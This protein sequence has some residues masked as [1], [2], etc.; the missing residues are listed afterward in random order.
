MNYSQTLGESKFFGRCESEFFLKKYDGY[1]KR[2]TAHE[3]DTLGNLV[4]LTDGEHGNAITSET[5]YAKYYGARNVLKGI[6]DEKD[7][8][9]IS[10]EHHRRIWK[11]RL[12]ANDVL[13]SCV[14]ANVGFASIVPDNVGEA[15]IVRNVAL[16][17]SLNPTVSNHYL[18]AY[19]LSKYGKELFIRMATGNAQ[20]LVSLDYIKTIPVYIP[21][22]KFQIKIKDAIES[23][24]KN[25]DESQIIYAQAEAMLL[26][27]IGLA[28]FEPSR[29]PVNVK[30]FKESFLATGRLDAEYY[31]IKYEQIIQRIKAQP[32][33]SL[34][35]LVLMTKSIEPGS[36]AY[37]DEGLPF[38]RVSDFNKYGLS[39][40]AVKLSKEYYRENVH[41]LEALKPKKGTILF[42][43]DGSVGVAYLLREN[44]NA[45]TSSAILH[46]NILNKEKVLPE[47]L[48]LVLNSTLVQMQAERD[49][50]GSIILHWRM[51][52]IENVVVPVI[53]IDIQK[54]IAKLIEESFTLK[55]ES[56][57]LLELAKKAVEV[58]IEQGEAAGMKL[59]NGG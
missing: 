32:H 34:Q 41:D 20:P 49:A 12:S 36:N 52:E 19:F 37:A 45:V 35:N 47:Y 42:S 54:K 50:G 22:E 5:G 11:S 25:L 1:L 53:D 31:Q 27:A 17:R 44:L 38:I 33:D 30:S 3:A 7:V 55:K 9:F 13:I 51:S 18:L 8:E 23:A 15:N 43:K 26:E 10:E 21:N 39:E 58:A 40:P 56:E 2:I 14:G 57:H 48:T 6:V 46:L 24:K 4:F 16:I 59:L 29:E 28:D